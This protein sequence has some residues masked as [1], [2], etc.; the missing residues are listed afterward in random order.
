[1]TPFCDLIFISF[2]SNT[3]EVE[4]RI[5]TEPERL[6]PEQRA[7]KQ[8]GEPFVPSTHHFLKPS[9]Q[10]PTNL[11][12]PDDSYGK[13]SHQRNSVPSNFTRT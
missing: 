10:C 4:N 9:P 7:G 6:V 11:P 12:S 5:P 1:M 2:H 3:N 13:I 8:W